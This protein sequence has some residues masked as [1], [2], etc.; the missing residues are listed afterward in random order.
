M[1]ISYWTHVYLS[2]IP[3]LIVFKEEFFN[4]GLIG[5]EKEVK[6]KTKRNDNIDKREET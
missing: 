6:E 1:I 4:Q 3:C 2:M 5:D